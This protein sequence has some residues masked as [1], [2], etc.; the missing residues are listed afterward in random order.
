M[1]CLKSQKV[2]GDKGKAVRFGKP[3]CGSDPAP[4]EPCLSLQ[5]SSLTQAHQEALSSLS[6]KAEGLE[7]SLNSLETRRA[8]E[9][10]ELA[11]AQREVE[12]LQKQLRYVGSGGP[13]GSPA[14]GGWGGSLDCPTNGYPIP[15]LN[16]AKPKKS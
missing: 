13:M 6:N 12:L 5:L 16:L 15:T 1:G 14:V 10:K 9:A 2:G 7:K 4:A 8:G 11:V 3:R